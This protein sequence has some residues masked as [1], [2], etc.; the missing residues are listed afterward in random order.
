MQKD[1]TK[2][3]KTTGNEF[4]EDLD[5]W[6][7]TQTSQGNRQISVE[8]VCKNFTG[9]GGPND[10]NYGLSRRMIDI[11]LLCLVREGKLRI[12]LSGKGAATAEYIDYTN[13]ADLTFNAALLNSMTKVQRLKAPE[14]WP[15]LAPYAAILLDDES[16]KSI[17]KDGDIAAALDRLRKWREQRNPEVV[18]LIE[19]LD[20]L[21]SDIGK[22]NPVTD[23]LQSWKAFVSAKIDDTEAIS[24]LLNALDK[25]FGYTC[26]AQQEAKM[27]E[28]DDLATRKKT[29]QKAEAFGRHDQKIRAA[30]RYA[31]LQVKKEGPVGELKEKLRSLGKKLENVNDLM[32]SEA[33]LQ[34]Q[35]LDQLDS[36]QTTYKTRYLQAFDEATGK[37]EQSRSE[38]ENLTDSRP[39]RAVAELAKLDALASVDVDQLREEVLAHKDGLFQ[40]SLDRN[41]VERALKD[42][43][44]PEGCSLPV[45]DAHQLVTEAEEAVER[46]RRVVRSSLVNLASLLRQP[47]LRTLLE[48]G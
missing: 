2:R 32:D 29:W 12:V 11:Y 26:Y 10:K 45:D 48:Q 31:Q 21:M 38:I 24:H 5:E 23:C 18:A 37:C 35:L 13:V 17:Q 46:A 14:G 28:L 34:S 25:S 22:T 36:V 27:M 3:L 41:A 9:L 42:R 20:A 16:L 19:R 33:K 47:A 44:Q 7:E 39:F 6:I 1:G 15:V 4:V 8:S 30:H 40:S 43:P